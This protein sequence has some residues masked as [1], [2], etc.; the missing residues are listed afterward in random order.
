MN[1][2][3]SHYGKELKRI[4]SPHIDIYAKSF[5]YLTDRV[6]RL[7]EF[8]KLVA[9]ISMVFAVASYSFNWGVTEIP[10][11][12]FIVSMTALM[13]SAIIARQLEPSIRAMIEYY[14]REKEKQS[15]E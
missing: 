4:D 3:V 13:V 15:K 2:T 7:R 8:S 6:V 5:G 1:L 14:K 12:I 9:Q 11:K 10:V